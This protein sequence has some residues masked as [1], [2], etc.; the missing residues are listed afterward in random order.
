MRTLG[1]T[2]AIAGM[3]LLASCSGTA[4]SVYDQYIKSGIRQRNTGESSSSSRKLLMLENDKQYGQLELAAFKT[5]SGKFLVV[6]SIKQARTFYI[7]DSAYTFDVSTLYDKKS[8][9]ELSAQAGQLSIHYTHI[10]AGMASA[11][12]TALMGMKQKYTQAAPGKDE[13]ISFDYTLSPDLV[14]S[15]EKTY[16]TQHPTRCTIWV[17]RRKHVVQTAALEQALEN[18][19]LF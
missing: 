9:P 2:L 19:K 15:L 1:K 3:A 11:F 6:G 14:I 8:S 18:L 10:D 16:K 7:H 12:Y 5:D 13:V 17:A 4:V